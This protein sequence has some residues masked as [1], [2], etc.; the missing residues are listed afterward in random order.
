MVNTMKDILNKIYLQER[1]FFT[2]SRDLLK[3]FGK[4]GD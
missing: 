4:V 3:V 1:G 2:L